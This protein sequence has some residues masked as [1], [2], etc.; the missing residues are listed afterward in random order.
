[1]RIIAIEDDA[2]MASV[3]ERKG[4]RMESGVSRAAVQALLKELP[5]GHLGAATAL[6]QSLAGSGRNSPSFE[7]VLG[8]K[9][10]RSEPGVSTVRIDVAPHLLNPHGFLHG[11]VLFAAM[12]SSMGAALMAALPEGERCTTVEAKINFISAVTEGSIDIETRVIHQ[13]GRIAVLE[14]RAENEAGK[15]VAIM[16]GTFMVIR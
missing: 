11:G 7:Q 13:G 8:F 5:D 10:D 1:V 12:D 4:T 16:T 9:A 3:G 2:T 14:S 6:L 15:L